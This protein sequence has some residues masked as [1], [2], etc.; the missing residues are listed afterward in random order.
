MI[1]WKPCVKSFYEVF[2]D[3]IA[4]E[5]LPSD[6]SN[7]QGEHKSA[8]DIFHQLEG[9]WCLACQFPHGK[10][11]DRHNSK[12]LNLPKD[13]RN[14]HQSKTGLW[15]QG[16]SVWSSLCTPSSH[17]PPIAQNR[18]VY[19]KRSRVIIFYQL[20]PWIPPPA[21][22]YFLPRV[23]NCM[24]TGTQILLWRSVHSLGTTLDGSYVYPSGKVSL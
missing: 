15:R 10:S 22:W 9:H 17:W 18:I 8:T 12:D 7:S 21:R 11:F 14:R 3:N 23:D 4:S 1:W 2:P 19:L 16:E 24:I 20:F 5:S 6:R 13:S